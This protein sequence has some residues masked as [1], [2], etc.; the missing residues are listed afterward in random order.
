MNSGFYAPGD[1]PLNLAA[2][3]KIPRFCPWGRT[4]AE[5]HEDLDSTN[6]RVRELGY[7]GSAEGTLV[8]T[9]RQ[10]AGRGRRGRN[11]HSPSGR[12]LYFSVLLRPALAPETTSLITLAAGLGA[13]KAIERL[14]GFRASLKWPN[15]LLWGQRKLAGI[16]T[17]LEMR[18]SRPD[19][20]VL[21]MG[22]NVNIAR[23]EMPAE[24]ADTAGS[25][26]EA[27]G[28]SWNR[29]ELLSALL[30]D[31]EKEYTELSLGGQAGL[32]EKYRR[33]CA[34]VGSR[35]IVSEAGGCWQGRA[36]DVDETGGLVIRRETDGVLTTVYSGE[37]SLLRGV[38]KQKPGS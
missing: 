9:E 31:I 33:V 10:T 6:L 29:L 13:V 14:T 37:V 21:G 34:T 20:A 38:N 26:L 17:E 32:L 15:D 35:V 24:L 30:E 16:L 3:R 12:N 1:G 2:W 25:L 4:G 7:S 5:F 8:A 18:G 11:W 27:T 19:F 23:S 36:E 28:R 22:V